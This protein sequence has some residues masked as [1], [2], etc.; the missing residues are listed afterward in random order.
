LNG[1]ISTNTSPTFQFCDSKIFSTA[2]VQVTVSQS[3]NVLNA[4]SLGMTC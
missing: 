3:D 1:C 4:L 2:E